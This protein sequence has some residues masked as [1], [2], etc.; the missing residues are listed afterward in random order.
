[1]T[2]IGPASFFSAR[3]PRHFVRF[4]RTSL[5]RPWAQ[6]PGMNAG[7]PGS[8][9]MENQLDW[10]CAIAAAGVIQVKLNMS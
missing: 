5:H 8:R 7:Q 6:N 10:P 9:E 4:N 2:G 1:M 3:L